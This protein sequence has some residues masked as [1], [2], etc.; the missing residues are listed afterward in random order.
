MN[1]LVNCKDKTYYKVPGG[2]HEVFYDS[3]FEPHA[4]VLSDWILKRCNK[5]ISLSSTDAIQITIE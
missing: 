3:G 4:K 2:F 5:E 1:A